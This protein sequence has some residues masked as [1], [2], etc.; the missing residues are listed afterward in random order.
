M[1]GLRAI[2]HKQMLSQ[3][4]LAEAAGLTAAS[5]SRY[6]TGHRKMPVDIAKRLSVALNTNW[7]ALFDEQIASKEVQ[8]A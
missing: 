1:N 6:E 3:R 7:T 8:G 2:R 5:I 4:E